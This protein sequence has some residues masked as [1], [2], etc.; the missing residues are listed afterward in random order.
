MALWKQIID[1]ISQ[2]TSN[3]RVRVIYYGRANM[4]T[5]YRLYYLLSYAKRSGLNQVIL[6][7]DGGFWLEESTPWLIE[8]GVDQIV[9][10]VDKVADDVAAIPSFERIAEL[11]A[12]MP[13]A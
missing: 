8:S 3:T 11:E 1:E 4:I 12:G 13:M 6:Q 10:A 2:D 7:T 5:G 9:V